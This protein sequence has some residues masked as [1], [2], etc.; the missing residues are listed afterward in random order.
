MPQQPLLIHR[1][2][3]DIDLYRNSP[4]GTLYLISKSFVWFPRQ[5]NTIYW[6]SFFSTAKVKFQPFHSYSSDQGFGS[7]PSNPVHSRL[8]YS[9]PH[10]LRLSPF[11]QPGTQQTS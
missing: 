9:L 7:D 1:A 11:S 10:P 8:N 6:K 4:C 3:D 2:P 5:E